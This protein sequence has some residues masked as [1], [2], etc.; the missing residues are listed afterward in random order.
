MRGGGALLC[1]AALRGR[2]F[3]GGIRAQSMKMPARMSTAAKLSGDQRILHVL[4][5]FGFGARRGDVE[6]LKA[7][8]IDN[9]ITQQL[10]PEKIDD[11][12]SEDKL[13]NLGTLRMSTAELYEKYP[14]PGQLLRQLQQRGALPADLAQARDNRVKGGANAAPA[15]NTQ[16]R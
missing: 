15:A 8:G 9:Y 10:W 11:A 4:N 7:M 12:A 13:Q 6:R 5:G 3:A 1:L 2:T 16:K 14:Q